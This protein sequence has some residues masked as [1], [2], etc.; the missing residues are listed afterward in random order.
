ML[1]LVANETGCTGVP[2]AEAIT[3]APSA[4]RTA[5][6]PDRLK[7]VSL[8]LPSSASTLANARKFRETADPYGESI[9]LPHLAQVPIPTARGGRPSLGNGGAGVSTQ[10]R[11]SPLQPTGLYIETVMSP[12][13]CSRGSRS[14]RHHIPMAR[15]FADVVARGRF[16]ALHA[17]AVDDT[18][19][20]S[21]STRPR[22]CTGA[23]LQRVL[24]SRAVASRLRSSAGKRRT[25]NVGRRQVGGSA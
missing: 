23:G 4:R 2:D 6:G 3:P 15:T 7:S 10:A 19:R 22:I 24:P 21:P 16:S 8:D 13:G 17:R 9:H 5:R 1:E 20:L 14:M 18:R 25:V 12:R 11:L